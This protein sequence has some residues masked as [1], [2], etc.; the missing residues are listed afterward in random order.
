MTADA[1]RR[2]TNQLTRSA[3]PSDAELLGRFVA[4][5]NGEAFAALIERHGPMV[6][7]VCRRV[8][9][10]WHLAEDAF[11]VTFVVLAR[12]AATVALNSLAGWLHEVAHRV[13]KDARR[14]TRRRFQRE[15][16]VDE[17]PNPPAPSSTPDTEL[18][19]VLDDELRKLPAKYRELLVACDLEGQPRQPV[20]AG[21]GIPEGTLSSR[22]TAARKMLANRLAKRGIAPAVVAG[23][24]VNGPSLAAREVPGVLLASTARI[25]SGAPGTVPA[26]VATLANRAIRAMTIRSYATWAVGILVAA[27]TLG[28]AAGR[29]TQPPSLPPKT[30]PS[31]PF[32]FRPD[33]KNPLAPGRRSDPPKAD[34]LNPDG[35]E[36]L[37]TSSA[38]IMYDEDGFLNLIDNDG[39]STL[40]VNFGKESLSLSKSARLSPDG[41]M[42]AYLIPA[43][44]NPNVKGPHSQLH[45]RKVNEQGAGTNLGVYCSFIVWS[46]DGTRIAY[47]DTAP[48]VGR[49]E[50]AVV[51]VATTTTTPLNLPGSHTVSDWTP[52]GNHLLTASITDQENELPVIRLHL[53]NLDGTEHKALTDGK[54]IA[55][56][57]RISP[58]GRRVLFEGGPLVQKRPEPSGPPK[59]KDSNDPYGL[60]VLD[61]ATE[62]WTRVDTDGAGWT[63]GHCWSPDGKRIA[64]TWQE[65][66]N[67]K[68]PADPAN[69]SVKARLVVCDPDGRNPKTI[70]S[71]TGKG[72]TFQIGSV[73]WR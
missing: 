65:R 43:V 27:A 18:G 5:R 28:L 4:E 63:F 37:T 34:P 60:Q 11:Q 35:P 31:E 26:V 50:H 51:T 19:R 69:A 32:T 52:D 14:A 6:F 58:D 49:H 10:D 17:L 54:L 59:L 71:A 13:A 2:V 73:D 8:L 48:G 7:G 55:K 40:P 29:P 24:A 42:L 66:P 30:E 67:S 12:R 45:V 3:R 36:A 1:V 20:A 41:K 72:W 64:Y 53:M 39:T 23:I 62:S 16:P 61:L 38:G 33:L 21:L 15:R 9:G 22:L 70:H 56:A 44:P 57:G 25:G 68:D 47:T 46:P